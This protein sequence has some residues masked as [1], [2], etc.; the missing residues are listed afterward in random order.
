[1][2]L[3]K[4]EIKFVIIAAISAVLIFCFGYFLGQAKKVLKEIEVV[5][6]EQSGAGIVGEITI[7]DEKTGAEGPLVSA[8]MP[9]VISGASG[10]VSEIKDDRI[11]L[12]GSGTNFAD[13]VQRDI[14]AIFNEQT[15][16]FE[17]NQ[18]AR[19]NGLAGLKQIKEG[20]RVLVES[21]EN[22]R[23]KT[24]FTVSYVNMVE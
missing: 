4:T 3:K 1:M 12:R 9:P 16:V 17:K 21:S 8:T 15:V 5:S 2:F 14:T 13:N 22:I 7:K 23:G 10:I 11:I 18:A 6:L 19:W 20:N 24:E